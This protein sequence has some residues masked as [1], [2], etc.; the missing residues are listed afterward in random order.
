M[1]QPSWRKRSAGHMTVSANQEAAPLRRGRECIL[2]LWRLSS[3][4]FEFSGQVPEIFT[5]SAPKL[6]S[7]EVLVNKCPDNP[8]TSKIGPHIETKRPQS[9]AHIW[10]SHPSH[11]QRVKWTA[12]LE[13]APLL[14]PQTSKIYIRSVFCDSGMAHF[15]PI[16]R[17]SCK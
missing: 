17:P 11:G 10:Q 15:C 16:F 9:Y 1:S 3:R 13:R 8:R 14:Y 2:N 5:F 6:F 12:P 4:N 7:R